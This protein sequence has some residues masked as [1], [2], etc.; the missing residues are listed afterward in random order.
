MSS[1]IWNRIKN[2]KLECNAAKPG[3]D[4]EKKKKK[5]EEVVGFP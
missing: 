5:R 4:S 1:K 2:K 3:G